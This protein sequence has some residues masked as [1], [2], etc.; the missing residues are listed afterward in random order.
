ME[1]INIRNDVILFPDE[2]ANNV[3]ENINKRLKFKE[4]FC[5]K[6]YGCYVRF[7]SLN[8]IIEAK[9]DFNDCSTK[10]LIDCTFE[11]FKPKINVEYFSVVEMVYP[12]G[13]VI[14]I[15]NLDSVSALINEQ[16]PI[17]KTINVMIKEISFNKIYHC[18]AEIVF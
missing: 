15:L 13:S 9:I 1:I 6:K 10:F 4:G 14:K 12:E 5:D 18:V 16:L 3:Y 7:I 8:E 17:G 11:I 2:L